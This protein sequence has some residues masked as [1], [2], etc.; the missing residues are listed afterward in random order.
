[1]AK[2]GTNYEGL[3]DTIEAVER[4]LAEL[5]KTSDETKKKVEGNLTEQFA[6]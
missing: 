6:D 2:S 3:L 4:K 5:G 1:M